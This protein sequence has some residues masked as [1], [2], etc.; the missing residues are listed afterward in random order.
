MPGLS[1]CT[2]SEL[3]G[4]EEEDPT[5]EVCS[6]GEGT[7]I[8]R[9]YLHFICI[10]KPSPPPSLPVSLTQAMKIKLPSTRDQ[11]CWGKAKSQRQRQASIFRAR[12]GNSNPCIHLSSSPSIIPTLNCRVQEFR[13]GLS[14]DREA[15]G[16]GAGLGSD[17][18]GAPGPG[19]TR[20]IESCLTSSGEPAQPP[21]ALRSSFSYLT[22]FLGSLLVAVALGGSAGNEEKSGLASPYPP[23]R[24]PLPHMHRYVCPHC[25]HSVSQVHPGAS[26][27]SLHS[28]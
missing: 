24:P 23:V 15:L 4:L 21:L 7:C 9:A 14:E 25:P 13:T 2:L 19:P 26:S 12:N 20:E 10:V 5:L 22:R 8:C 17:K 28:P 16:W 1:S 11:S 3:T 27:P 18:A 6:L